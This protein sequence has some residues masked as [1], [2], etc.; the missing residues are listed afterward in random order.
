MLLATD[1]SPNP[2]LSCRSS[3]FTDFRLQN[4]ML[5]IMKLYRELQARKPRH[6][7]SP[8]LANETEL[9]LFDILIQVSRT[10]LVLGKSLEIQN[11]ESRFDFLTLA[12]GFIRCKIYVPT[13]LLTCLVYSNLAETLKQ[14]STVLEVFLTETITDTLG[15]RSYGDTLR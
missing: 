12:A 7:T 4:T 8:L 2:F 1:K 13:L 9:W 5:L 11:W 14:W 10:R 6:D 15:P 3:G